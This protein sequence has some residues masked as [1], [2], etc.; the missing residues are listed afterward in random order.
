[1]LF[2]S[3]HFLHEVAV[4]KHEALLQEQIRPIGDENSLP[5]LHQRIKTSHVSGSGA[6][7]PVANDKPTSSVDKLV[8]STSNETT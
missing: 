7:N 1:M 8:E 2:G 4:H 6:K 5:P 3:S